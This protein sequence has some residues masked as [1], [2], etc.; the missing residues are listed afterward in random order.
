M[1]SIC[2]VCIK[3]K[4]QYHQR[5]IESAD[6]HPCPPNTIPPKDSTMAD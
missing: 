1:V 2:P 3:G 5:I 6:S 4:P